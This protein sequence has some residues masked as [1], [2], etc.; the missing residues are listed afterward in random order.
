MVGKLDENMPVEAVGVLASAGWECDTVYDEALGG[1]EDPE[2]AA[3][4]RR[5][6][7]VLTL[8]QLGSAS[9]VSG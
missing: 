8:N 6:R 3:V 7:R 1:A 4:C 9:Q 5:E 2:V